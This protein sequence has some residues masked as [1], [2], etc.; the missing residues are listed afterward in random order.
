VTDLLNEL[1]GAAVPKRRRGR[2]RLDEPVTVAKAVTWGENG[3]GV[4]SFQVTL[5]CGKSCADI[6][7]VKRPRQE[8]LQDAAEQA[9]ASGGAAA[10]ERPADGT[11]GA[12][13]LSSPCLTMLLRHVTV[14]VRRCCFI[15]GYAGDGP[16]LEDAAGSPACAEE[17]VAV[18][19][20]DSAAAGTGRHGHGAQSDTCKAMFYVTSVYNAA[21]SVRRARTGRSGRM[22]RIVGLLAPW[23]G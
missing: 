16:V 14:T 15:S 5:P 10:E 9:E 21:P 23:G 6:S 20:A 18:D 2:P 4:E 3:L 7:C 17:A 13:D 8:G 19:A 22:G 1:A 11:G 12:Q